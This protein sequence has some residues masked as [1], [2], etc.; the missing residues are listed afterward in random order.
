MMKTM[1][2]GFALLFVVIYTSPIQEHD[3]KCCPQDPASL[4][5]GGDGC[6]DFC[7]GCEGSCNTEVGNLGCDWIECALAVAKCIDS[8]CE[9]SCITDA[10][11][12]GCLGNSY[13]TCKD[14]W[15]GSEIDRFKNL[16]LK[17]ATKM[18]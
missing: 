3:L 9:G 18:A 14:C 11:C 17:G 16:I 10:S 13:E 5:C 1:I 15:S 7:C 4:K 12:I 2:L 8:C 6:N